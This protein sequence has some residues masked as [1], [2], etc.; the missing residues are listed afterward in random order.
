MK[1][2]KLLFL[3][4]ITLSIPFAFTS[5]E[6]DGLTTEIE[7]S[8]VSFDIPL[9]FDNSN[10]LDDSNFKNSTVENF[11]SFSGKSD[12]I[13]LQSA[14]FSELDNNLIKSVQ[15][16]IKSVYIQVTPVAGTTGGTSVRNFKSKYT[17]G[18]TVLK[19]F[20]VGETIDL[21]TK[22]ESAELYKYL[23]GFFDGIQNNQTLVIDVNG[24]TDIVPSEISQT[25]FGVITIIPTITAKIQLLKK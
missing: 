24:E 9:S 1:T 3:I 7:L 22:Y 12:P 20:S 13:N 15:F 2:I 11:H 19:T 25:E 23:S 5:C 17:E 18:E 16:I 10:S 6:E 21:S 8:D 14:I 4:L